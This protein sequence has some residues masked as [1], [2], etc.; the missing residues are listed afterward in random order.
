MHSYERCCCHDVDAD[1]G[2]QRDR[3][4]E[5]IATD[6]WCRA[7]PLR[8]SLRAQPGISFGHG[9]DHLSTFTGDGD[10]IIVEFTNRFKELHG[11]QC[12]WIS[13]FSEESEVLFMGGAKQIR[14]VGVTVMET[15][16][17][18]QVYFRALGIFNDM[19][20]GRKAVWKSAQ[21]SMI[22]DLSLFA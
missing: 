15:K 8:H 1:R 5:A 2:F 3:E 12:S 16:K 6:R 9:M 13:T 7:V 18:Y 21:E 22:C 10:G 19:I 11:F 20:N 14:I 17:N 4:H